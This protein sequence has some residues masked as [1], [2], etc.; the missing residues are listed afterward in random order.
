M[1]RENSNQ[2]FGEAVGDLNGN[3]SSQFEIHSTFGT[4]KKTIHILSRIWVGGDFSLTK[5]DCVKITLKQTMMCHTG[6]IMNFPNK[7]ELKSILFPFFFSFN[8]AMFHLRVTVIWC[9]WWALKLWTQA[10]QI[11]TPDNT[12]TSLQSDLPTISFF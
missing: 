9:W 5:G 6:T 2:L 12:R 4:T 8:R 11:G 1:C 7:A 3:F 10:S